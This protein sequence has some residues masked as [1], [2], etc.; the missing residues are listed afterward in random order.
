MTVYIQLEVLIAELQ[1]IGFH[2]K[3]VGLL[4]SAINRARA[5]VFGEDAYPTIS[6]KAAATV[7][8]IIK[9][10]PMIDGNKRT[11]WFVLNLFLDLND[12]LLVS[13]Q[14]DAFDYLLGVAKGAIDLDRSEAWIESHTLSKTI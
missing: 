4:D 3:D 1:R 11:S 13:T 10:H 2:V 14:S 7:E 9:N 6:R 8:S 12:S 5:S